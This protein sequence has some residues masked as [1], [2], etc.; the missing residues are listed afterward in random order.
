MSSETNQTIY[1]YLKTGELAAPQYPGAGRAHGYTIRSWSRAWCGGL[2]TWKKY[3]HLHRRLG[4]NNISLDLSWADIEAQRG[5]YDFTGYDAYL[6]VIVDA[7][8]TLQLK[9]NSRMMPAW[10]MANR[11]A[12]LCDADGNLVQGEWPGVISSPFHGFAD[13]QTIAGLQ[14]FYRQVAEHCRG[15]PNLFY[16]SAF[17]C[18]FE[19]EYHGTIWTDYSPAAQ[20]QFRT[21][22]QAVYPSLDKLNAAWLTQYATWN[23]VSIAW[24]P[25]E[26]MRGDRPDARYVDFMKYREWAGRRFFDALHDALKAGDARAEY[27]PQVGR[28][29][30]PVGMLRGAISAFHW[31]ENCEWIFVDPAPTDDYAWEM[32]IA[33]A[34]GKKVAVEL[35]GPDM[36]RRLHCEP[37]LSTL[38]ADQTRWCY[39][40]GA[41]YV[42][43]ANWSELRDYE[44]GVAAGMFQHAAAA[45]QG[46]FTIPVA[47]DAVYVGKW[48]SYLRRFR[49]WEEQPGAV[50]ETAKACFQKLRRQGR[51]VD[52]VLDDTILQRPARLKQ[53][54]RIH[55]DGARFIARPVWDALRQSG[56]DLV[57][58]EGPQVRGDET[59]AALDQC[60]QLPPSWAP[61]EN[62][63]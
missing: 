23:D 38:Y 36:Y 17:A 59:G 10:A 2:A 3:V 19:S 8:L 44:R 27:G 20:R 12:L 9:L 39:E 14:G 15:L 26:T 30:C 50:L 25:G 24:R 41:D 53:Y 35:D 5:T 29:V 52:V 47:A 34:G 32:A 43:H 58:P 6:D 54:A 7:G 4:Y 48:D 49:E 21:Y 62:P 55:L 45:K 57:F 60:F 28:I 18:S 42:C 40:H 11:D 31:A 37:Q 61:Y 51:A 22:L 16:C 1:D 56:A 33:R 46:E 63:S 13:P